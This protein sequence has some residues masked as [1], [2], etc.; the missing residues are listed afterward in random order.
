MNAAGRCRVGEALASSRKAR[1]AEQAALE[2][3]LD[4]S[5]NRGHDEE[6]AEAAA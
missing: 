3:D 1:Q 6:A 4:A 2:A 5:D